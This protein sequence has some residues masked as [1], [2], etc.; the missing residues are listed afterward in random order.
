MTTE[1]II[2]IIGKLIQRHLG[3]LEFMILCGVAIC[4]LLLWLIYDKLKRGK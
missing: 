4:F 2:W 1:Q 3:W